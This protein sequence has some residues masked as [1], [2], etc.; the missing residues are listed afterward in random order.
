MLDVI[1][2]LILVA[3]L[4]WGIMKKLN[5]AFIL[6]VLSLV[7]MAGVQLVTG[8]SV[9]GED[10]TG[11]LFFDLFENVVVVAGSQLSKNVLLVMTVMGYVFVCEKINATKMFAVYAAKPFMKIKNHYLVAVFVVFLG[12]FLKLAITS[13]SSLCTM[14]LATMYPVMR[15]AGCSKGTA[16]TAVT[17]PGCVI[18][19]P[20][21]A[22]LYLAFTLAGRED[23]SVVEFFTHYQIPMVIVILIVFAITVPLASKLW[24]KRELAKHTEEKE[25]AELK[26]LSADQLGV[27]RFYALFP[28]LPLIIILVFSEL[29]P[30]TPN[31]SVG[32]AHWICLCLIIVV[33]MIVK[34]RF[35]GSFNL[36]TDFIKGMANYLTLGGMIM[37]GAALFSSALN[38]VGGMANI[39]KLLTSNGGGYV[40][41]LIF[42]VI[43]GYIIAAFSHV[44]PALNIFVPLFVAVCAASGNDI[45]L[46][47]LAL[48]TGACMGIAI[49]PT[50]S[51]LVIASGTTGV[52]IPG[53]MKRNLIPSIAAT[54]AVII[55]TLVMFAV[56]Y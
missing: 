43:L 5:P 51:A 42:A 48:L 44:S 17:L 30:A 56:G 24:D 14:L 28:I 6:I 27:P 50:N 7:T 49:L 11:S 20:S 40:V 16:A 45:R 36:S 19:G 37:V 9:M 38:S 12:V 18:W 4:I 21:D 25:E 41:T 46:M 1:I 53:I 23:I 3:L 10:T 39:G 32:A 35:A 13:S 52:S 8:V 47:I 31:I 55:T 34:K 29:I 33:D 54:V 22:T 2:T 15:A 26:I